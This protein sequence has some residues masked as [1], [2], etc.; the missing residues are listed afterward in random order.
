MLPLF[1]VNNYGQFNH[2]IHRMLRDL[3]IPV[4]MIPNT[5]IPSEIEGR[6]RGIIL[7]GGP[8]IDRIGRCAEYLD[9]GI[10]VL[11]ICL[12][13][14]LIAHSLGGEIGSGKSG[15]YGG[16]DVTI[17]NHGGILDGYPDTIHVW[18]SHADEVK[19]APDGF[20]ILATSTICEIEAMACHEKRIFG[21]QWHPE[22]SHSENGSLIYQNFNEICKE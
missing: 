8:S 18:A 5:T 2:L 15:G 11:G 20:T 13:H 7:G 16:V 21:L 1:V 6:C 19:R 9:L 10:P 4:M 14:Q 22:V 3:D 12:G 17:R